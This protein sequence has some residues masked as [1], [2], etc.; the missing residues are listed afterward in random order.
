MKYIHIRI[1]PV[2]NEAYTYE[3][4]INHAYE[5]AQNLTGDAL[6]LLMPFWGQADGII[7]MYW[8]GR[9]GQISYP[10]LSYGTF[11]PDHAPDR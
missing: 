2:W 7:G 8:G 10:A 5:L 11:S 6:L 1:H 4:R 3:P 9:T